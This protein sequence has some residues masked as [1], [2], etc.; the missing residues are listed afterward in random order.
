[1]EATKKEIMDARSE[2][3]SR[4]RRLGFTCVSSDRDVAIYA[5]TV[6]GVELEVQLWRDGRHRATHWRK[7]EH[8]KHQVT[9]PTNFTT[10]EGMISALSHEVTRDALGVGE[11]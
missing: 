4:L 5:G 2:M 11:R 1:M 6:L 7:Y 9:S 8:G 3:M 10:M